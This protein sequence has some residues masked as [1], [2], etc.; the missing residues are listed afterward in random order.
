MLAL[1]FLT[2]TSNGFIGAN[3]LAGALAVDPLRSGSASGLFGASSFLVGAGAAT[4][5]AAFHDGTVAPLAAVMAA[6]LA[7]GT[8]ALYLLALPRRGEGELA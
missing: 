8:L 3:A 5:A 7:L 2:L 4:L 1:F 6:S